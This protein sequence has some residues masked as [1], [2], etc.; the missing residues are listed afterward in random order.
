[1]ASDFNSASQNNITSLQSSIE[2]LKIL[3]E[4]LG[5]RSLE[6]QMIIYSSESQDS[7]PYLEEEVS[8]EVVESLCL[9][10]GFEFVDM[11]LE[12]TFDKMPELQDEEETGDCFVYSLDVH[13]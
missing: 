8:P 3:L 10:H 5:L 7:G 11:S 6:F 13:S 2:S 4:R 12:G 1:V 9:E